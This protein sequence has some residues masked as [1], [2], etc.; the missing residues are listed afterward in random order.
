MATEQQYDDIIAPMLAAEIER[1]TRERDGLVSGLSALVHCQSSLTRSQM[2][3]AAADL[4]TAHGLKPIY[5]G[6]DQ[7]PF[8]T[9]AESAEA[10]LARAREALEFYANPKTY[11][12][13]SREAWREENPTKDPT[14]A[15]RCGRFSVEA[16]PGFVIAP[17]H[18][19]G[20]GNR[21]RAAL[22]PR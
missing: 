18:H 20:Q 8:V 5:L 17:I 11:Q 4:L 7:S 14:V 13:Q 9:R 12:E 16:N 6:G 15:M 21:A 2:R 10:D 1:L 22:T 3:E 19:D